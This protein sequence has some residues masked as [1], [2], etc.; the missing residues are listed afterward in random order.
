M[1]VIVVVLVIAVTQAPDFGRIIG[2]LRSCRAREAR[3]D[4]E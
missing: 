4:S 2:A 3:M 1:V